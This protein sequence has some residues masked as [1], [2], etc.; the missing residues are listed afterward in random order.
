M[1]L[2]FTIV[3]LSASGF[4]L[5]AQSF[6]FYQNGKALPNDTTIE[7]T[8]AIVE[9]DILM[10][11]PELSFKNMTSS[12]LQVNG[13]QTI[14][15]NS[16]SGTLAYCFGTQC[17]YG[18]IDQTSSMTI[19]ADQTLKLQLEFIP[20]LGTYT[21]ITVKY[22]A[23]IG[24]ERS[25]VTVK[26]M[27]SESSTSSTSNVKKE[28]FQVCRQANGTAVIL[29]DETENNTI[30]DI[31]DLTGKLKKSLILKNNTVLNLSKGIYLLSLKKNNSILS[32]QK[33]ICY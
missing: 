8:K 27:Y 32:T 13:T 6:A 10:L 26:Y 21:T 1:R 3:L 11:T 31:Y 20:E 12:S 17:K 28:S 30:L 18:N 2:F 9:N 15:A 22:Q 19:G 33:Y 29:Y 25:S 4:M 14:I 23:A 5:Q 16:E 24:F 7:I